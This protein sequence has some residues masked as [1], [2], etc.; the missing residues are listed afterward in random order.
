[1]L[2]TVF[3]LSG[4]GSSRFSRSNTSEAE[5]N[6]DHKECM[7]KAVSEYP[8]KFE[9][10]YN[11]TITSECTTNKKGKTICT[12]TEDKRLEDKNADNQRNE[13]I[14]CMNSKGYTHK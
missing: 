6:K 12:H 4:C 7:Q 10:V 3:I 14:R 2:I 8:S 9:W 13:T 11:G 5:R 1:M